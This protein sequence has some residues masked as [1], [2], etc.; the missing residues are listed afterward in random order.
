MDRRNEELLFLR[1]AYRR[2][3]RSATGFWKFSFG[4]SLLV[5]LL[6][7]PCLI[8]AWLPQTSTAC[9]LG[10]GLIGAGLSLPVLS[11]ILVCYSNILLIVIGVFLLIFVLSVL[12]WIR[13]SRRLKRTDAFLSYRT[14]RD[15]LLEEKKYRQ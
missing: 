10:S 9:W 12:M 13:G 5:L 15:T 7:V 11:G 8:V 1:K 3:K 14:L 4:I 2:E 6:A